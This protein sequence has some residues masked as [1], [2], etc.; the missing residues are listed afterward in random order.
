MNKKKIR[1]LLNVLL[2]LL[3]IVLLAGL[4]QYLAVRE[5]EAAQENGVPYVEMVAEDH[6]LLEEFRLRHPERTIL[7]ACSESITRDDVPDLVVISQLGDDISTIALY[8]GADGVLLETPPIPAP[9]ENQHIRFFNMDNLG[10]IETL[11]T[12]E[13]N[14][15]VGYAIYRIMDGEMINLF[16]EGMEDCC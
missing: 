13:K 10:E 12:G 16:G 3:A 14:G 11:I 15:Q 2:I 1:L 5:E 8:N 6:P 4:R 7:L 9:R